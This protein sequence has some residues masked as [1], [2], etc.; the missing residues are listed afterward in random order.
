MIINRIDGSPQFEK[1]GPA[2]F[3]KN[4]YD[5]LKSLGKIGG[6]I[7]A[8]SLITIIGFLVGNKLIGIL[9]ILYILSIVIRIPDTYSDIFYFESVATFGLILTLVSSIPVA[10]FFVI[11]AEWLTKFISP[12]GPV[13]NY[14]ET[15]SESVAVSIAIA[16]S[17]LLF[18]KGDL[19]QYMIYF[20]AARFSIYYIMLFIT[21]P[22]TIFHD[23]LNA[24]VIIPLSIM[25][26]YLILMLL[27]NF[28]F[29]MFG[30][31][32]WKLGSLITFFTT[33]KFS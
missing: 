11:T 5:W 20:H 14:T 26:S 23:L 1:P 13:E 4:T 24:V 27:G 18:V 25:Q 8:F 10:L 29:D 6:S 16:L 33:G 3:F 30:I 17:P 12:F 7:F 15:F 22:A 28:A 32:G 31:T 2:E 21:E 9:G 19:L